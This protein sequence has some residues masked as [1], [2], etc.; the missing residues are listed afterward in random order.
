[1]TKQAAWSALVQVQSVYQRFCRNF[2]SF[3]VDFIAHDVAFFLLF[4]VST[5]E[6]LLP[7]FWLGCSVNP[8]F[9]LYVARSLFLLAVFFFG[10][11]LFVFGFLIERNAA[12]KQLVSTSTVVFLSSAAGPPVATAAALLPFSDGRNNSIGNRPGQHFHNRKYPLRKRDSSVSLES[13][14]ALINSYGSVL[15]QKT[16]F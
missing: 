16:R 3:S 8:F 12:L 5:F 10:D 6:T 9:P 2:V 15:S 1:M 7:F 13:A 14:S 11:G 4:C